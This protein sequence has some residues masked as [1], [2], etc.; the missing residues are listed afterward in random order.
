MQIRTELS[1]GNLGFI[2]GSNQPSW[3]LYLAVT[4]VGLASFVYTGVAKCTIDTEALFLF[5]LKFRFENSLEFS[6]TLFF[7]FAHWK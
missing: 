4:L 2:F 1:Y 6:S 5:C 7:P 3:F